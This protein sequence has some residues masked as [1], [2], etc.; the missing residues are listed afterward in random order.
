MAIIPSWHRLYSLL[1][2][3]SHPL[4]DSRSCSCPFSRLFYASFA[5]FVI[6]TL[7]FKLLPL[8]P[9]PPPDLPPQAYQAPQPQLR[10]SFSAT[11]RTARALPHTS[12]AWPF[13]ASSSR[14]AAVGKRQS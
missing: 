7:T 1:D 2:R 8:N 4:F 5:I 14:G 13:Y 10:R 6:L 12:D 11:S 3:S 9:F